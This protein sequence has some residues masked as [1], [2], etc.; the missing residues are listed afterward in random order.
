MQNLMSNQ[1]LVY[2]REDLMYLQ[3]ELQE[4]QAKLNYMHTE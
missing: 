2:A 1:K 3:A 4:Q